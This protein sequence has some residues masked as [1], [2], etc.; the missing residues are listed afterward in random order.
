METLL[1]AEQIE[2]G[3]DRMAAYVQSVCPRPPLVL[4]GVLTGSL[5]M[6]ADLIRRLDLPLRLALIQA[7]SYRGPKHQQGE[8][9]IDDRLLPDLRGSHVV[10][11]DDIFDTGQTL[12]GVVEQLQRRRPSS[13]HSAVLLRK[14]IGGAKS[15]EPDF[16]AFDIPDKFVV[17]YGLDLNDLYRNLPYVATLDPGEGP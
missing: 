17:G 14:Q 3:V 5:P 15:V 6:V 7:R 9:K 13:L 16:V 4:V 10:V 11:V 8:L 1:N 2:E 12:A